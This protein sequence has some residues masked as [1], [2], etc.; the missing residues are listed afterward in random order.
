MKTLPH[1][2]HYICNHKGRQ[3][4]LELKDH[5]MFIYIETLPYCN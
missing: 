2:Y 5:K 1:L 3:G 4:C